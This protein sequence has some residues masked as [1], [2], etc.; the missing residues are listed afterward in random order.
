MANG[1]RRTIEELRYEIEEARRHAVGGLGGWALT[2]LEVSGE[3]LE[4]VDE[5]LPRKPEPRRPRDL[6]VTCKQCQLCVGSTACLTC[7]AERGDD[8]TTRAGKKAAHCHA[9][10]FRRALLTH[11]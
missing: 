4:H 10:R 5:M 9:S 8:C 7:Q 3:L 11:E 1:V 2:L 6:S